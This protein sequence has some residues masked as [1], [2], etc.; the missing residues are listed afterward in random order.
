MFAWHG[1]A[2]FKKKNPVTFNENG[3]MYGKA[4]IMIN[5]IL[6]EGNL[7]AKVA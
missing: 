7:H 5:A 2:S 4:K 1:M 6:N 3:I